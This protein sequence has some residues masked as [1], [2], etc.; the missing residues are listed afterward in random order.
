MHPNITNPV[1]TVREKIVEHL[2][3]AGRPLTSRELCQILGLRAK[4]LLEHVEH[5][6]KS[7]KKFQGKIELL[8]AECKKCGFDFPGRDRY[9]RPGKCPKCRSQHIEPP[10]FFW[11]EEEAND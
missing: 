2:R 4:D 7:Q 1:S 6:Q 10:A 8:S 11:R 9:S 5:I 3:Q